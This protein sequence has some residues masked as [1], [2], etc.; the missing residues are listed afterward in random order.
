MA[1]KDSITLNNAMDNPIKIVWAFKHQGEIRERTA[2]LAEREIGYE[3]SFVNP[4]DQEH[5]LKAI[6]YLVD[7][8]KILIAEKVSDKQM[9]KQQEKAKKEDGKKTQEVHNELDKTISEGALQA[10]GGEVKNF[11][12]ETEKAKD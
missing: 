11:Q 9:S 8:G 3:V 12:V 2:I 7:E 1:K 10:T 5:F 6:E 4:Q